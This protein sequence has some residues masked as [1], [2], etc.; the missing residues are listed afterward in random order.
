MQKFCFV[1]FS[2]LL[3]YPIHLT[4]LSKSHP[5]FN[6][7]NCRMTKPSWLE[8]AKCCVTHAAELLKYFIPS[9]L[10]ATQST[11]VVERTKL[12]GIGQPLDIGGGCKWSHLN[13]MQVVESTFS[14]NL[15]PL[16][17][18]LDASD[19]ESGSDLLDSGATLTSFQH[20][21]PN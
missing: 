17:R 20:F 4:D 9:H 8:S 3:H 16:R 2:T 14:P 1:S 18:L 15:W 21:Y 5:T 7:P 6:L 19:P 12:G 10:I 13:Q 11:T